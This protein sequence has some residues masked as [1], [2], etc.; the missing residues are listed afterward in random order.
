MVKQNAE[1]TEHHLEMCFNFSC[2]WA[3]GALLDP[4]SKEAFSAWWR[5]T[6]D[7]FV[8]FPSNGTVSNFTG[9]DRYVIEI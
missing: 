4:R 5:Q 8:Q 3:F 6:F 9:L 2:V 7:R 1:M